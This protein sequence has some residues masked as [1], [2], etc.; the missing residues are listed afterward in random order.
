MVK[1]YLWIVLI[2][3]RINGAELA[4]P[5]QWP[6]EASVVSASSSEDDRPVSV[7]VQDLR[8]VNLQI[9]EEAF[10]ILAAASRRSI[11][12]QDLIPLQRSDGA[13]V[14]TTI[15]VDQ[16]LV[17][18]QP[19]EEE[20]LAVDASVRV[21]AENLCCGCIKIRDETYRDRVVSSK[22][23]CCG[24]MKIRGDSYINRF[25]ISRECCWG[26]LWQVSN[27]GV[28]V[29]R[30][31]YTSRRGRMSFCWELCSCGNLRN[32]SL[33]IECCCCSGYRE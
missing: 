28:D 22:E 5:G 7:P 10:A 31:Y 1:K 4:L 8:V 6:D 19:V 33:E 9:S 21:E 13:S 2:I 29:D 25:V 17:V 12:A 32:D 26:C 16:G 27:Y 3:G 11:P 24:C 23:S 14:I 20:N 18:Q 15:P 30:Q